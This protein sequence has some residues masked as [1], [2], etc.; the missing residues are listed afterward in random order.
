MEAHEQFTATT[1]ARLRQAV[2]TA[3]RSDP[4]PYLAMWS[5]REPVSLLGR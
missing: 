2:D 4:E 5:R 1:L 3:D